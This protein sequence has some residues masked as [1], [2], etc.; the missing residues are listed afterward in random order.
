MLSENIAIVSGSAIRYK[1][2]SLTDAEVELERIGVTYSFRK[3]PANTWKIVAGII[4]EPE[5]AI[6]L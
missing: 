3:A 1:K 4:H 2:D 5:N 6:A